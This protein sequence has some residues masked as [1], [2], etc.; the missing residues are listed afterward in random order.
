MTFLLIGLD[1]GDHGAGSQPTGTT[2][3]NTACH[4]TKHSE[5]ATTVPS[6]LLNFMTTLIGVMLNL[7]G[8]HI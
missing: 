6:V 4:K 3:Q 5:C 1:S 2:S 7:L 8:L